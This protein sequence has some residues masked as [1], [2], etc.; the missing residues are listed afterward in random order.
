M[1][2]TAKLDRIAEVI[3]DHWPEQ[4]HHSELQHPALI[5]DV[6]SA[7]AALLQLLGLGSLV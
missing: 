7:R 5:A 3:R 6:E 2:D 4:I 1:V